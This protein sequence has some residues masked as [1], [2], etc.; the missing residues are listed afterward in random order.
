MSPPLEPRGSSSNTHRSPV[1]PHLAAAPRYPDLGVGR[2]NSTA[3][4]YPSNVA[5]NDASRHPY[6][7]LSSHR[8]VSLQVSQTHQ[9][10]IRVASS[11]ESR[12]A[13]QPLRSGVNGKVV[14]EANSL[15]QQ[16]LHKPKSK[17]RLRLKLTPPHPPGTR[18]LV[19]DAPLPRHISNQD[20]ALARA[21]SDMGLSRTESGDGRDKENAP[22]APKHPF[23]FN[24]ARDAA[25]SL[26]KRHA[27]TGHDYPP[28]QEQARAHQDYQRGRL[29]TPSHGRNITSSTS[30]HRRVPSS[31]TTDERVKAV[32]EAH[33][34]RPAPSPPKEPV[35]TINNQSRSSEQPRLTK[36]L[37]H[38]DP[39]PAVSPLRVEGHGFQPITS[40]ST[41]VSANIPHPSGKEDRV[42]RDGIEQEASSISLSLTVSQED[43]HVFELDGSREMTEEQKAFGKQSHPIAPILD[44][45]PLEVGTPAAQDT[46]R[47]D[48]SWATNSEQQSLHTREIDTVRDSSLDVSDS[49]EDCDNTCWTSTTA[50][51]SGM[52]GEESKDK[53]GEGKKT[54]AEGMSD[55]FSVGLFCTPPVSVTTS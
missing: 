54:D 45:Q 2:P 32:E 37:Y 28:I 52:V 13:L 26:G 6:A 33:L 30:G 11:Q 43:S 42:E 46:S 10:S 38:L 53:E 22:I 3:G 35:F 47:V 36:T 49:R 23:A 24:D 14:N 20:A 12:Q 44:D 5:P 27:T 15:Q 1:E 7:R 29:E 51:D 34:R 50:D 48:Q 21:V 4:R 17:L 31:L 40:C 41:P 19:P 39:T 16:T 18:L 25:M 9:T 8:E 55:V